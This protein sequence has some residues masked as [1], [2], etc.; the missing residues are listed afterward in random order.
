MA[1]RIFALALGYEDINDHDALRHDPLLAVLV[2]KPTAFV[3]IRSS[4]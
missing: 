3:T 1:Q 4:S 2:G